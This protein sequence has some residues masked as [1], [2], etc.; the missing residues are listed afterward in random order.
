MSWCK[1]AKKNRITNIFWLKKAK[2]RA[3]RALIFIFLLFF[4][5]FRTDIELV[6]GLADAHEGPGAGPGDDLFGQLGNLFFLLFIE[7]AQDEVDLLALGEI[8]ADAD[9]EARPVLA[10]QE[11]GDVLQAVVATVGAGGAQAQCPEGEVDVV[12]DDEDVVQLDVQLLL[13]VADGVA[14]QIHVGGWLQEMEFA[15]FVA[16]E[17][18]VAVAAGFEND[19]G[20]LS[21]GIQYHKANVVSRGGVFGTDVAES[22]DQVRLF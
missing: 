10:L 2:I 11:L 9:A 21:P 20:C 19:I 1:L 4:R 13:P 14:G 22:D 18:H 8:V 3:F 7:G 5:H 12:A 15:A 17:G 6:H 16:D